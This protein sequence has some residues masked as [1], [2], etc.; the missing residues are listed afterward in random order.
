MMSSVMLWNGG[1]QFTSGT[2]TMKQHAP[3]QLSPVNFPSFTGEIEEQEGYK[4]KAEA[5]TRQTAF[6]FYSPEML[7]IKNRRR[8]TKNY[9]M[10]LKIHSMGRRRI[11]SLP[12]H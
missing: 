6:K 10:S 5:Q 9:S 3:I 8:E 7:Q 12:N 2:T 1:T 11:A 4:T